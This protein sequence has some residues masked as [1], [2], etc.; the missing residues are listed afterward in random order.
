MKRQNGKNQT[1]YSGIWVNDDLQKGFIRYY[2]SNNIEIG[3]YEG[4]IEHGKKHGNGTYTW[5]N[6]LKGMIYEGSFS[7]DSLTGWGTL[8]TKE[9]SITGNFTSNGDLNASMEVTGTIT[10]SNKDVFRGSFLIDK[11]TL[12]RYKGEY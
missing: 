7:N 11:N 3:N 4:A 1:I 5:L 2:D 6:E 10:Y 8:K 12:R 9:Y